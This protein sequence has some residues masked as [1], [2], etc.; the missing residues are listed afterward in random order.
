MKKRGAKWLH[1][2]GTGHDVNALPSV[3]TKLFVLAIFIRTVIKKDLKAQLLGY[4]PIKE[5]KEL[6]EGAIPTIFVHK[7]YEQINMVLVE[8]RRCQEVHL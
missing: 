3:G 7:I 6:V 5:R 1:N 4:K 8:R 2:M